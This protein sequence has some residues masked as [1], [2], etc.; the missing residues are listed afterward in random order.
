MIETPLDRAVI[1]MTAA[2][3]DETLRLRFFDRLAESDLVLLL[4]ADPSGEMIEPMLFDPGSGSVALAFDRELRLADFAGAAKPYA[5]MSGR[6]LAD[7]LSGA[8][9]GLALNLGT[10][11]E[12]L[13]SGEEIAWLAGILVER[14]T[15]AM[16]QIRSVRLPEGL[17]D[18]IIRAIEDKFG[19]FAGL[20]STAYLVAA[21]Y[22]DGRAGYVLAFVDVVPEAE[23]A[24]AAAIGEALVFSG[25]DD[26]SI[27]VIFI[28]SS[29]PV[30]DRLANVGLRIDLPE[31]ERP[32]ALDPT[33]PP[34][35]K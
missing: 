27:D 25:E 1:A 24:L 2:P 3:E 32:R 34:R 6:K 31:A 33:L 9:L 13:L 7:L 11:A 10:E 29:D 18:R 28:A 17:P 26:R 23:A 14:P 16:D 21:D 12:I 20:A 8:G 22:A 5:A 35:L 15:A 19:T 4:E 30:L